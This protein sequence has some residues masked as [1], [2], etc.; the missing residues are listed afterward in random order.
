MKERRVF[1][2]LCCSVL[3]FLLSSLSGC[4]R[5]ASREAT[6]SRPLDQPRRPYLNEILDKRTVPD[7]VEQP[8]GMPAAGPSGSPGRRPAGGP[9]GAPRFQPFTGGAR[10]T[11][12]TLGQVQGFLNRFGYL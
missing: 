5:Q 3:A 2:A 1:Q 8:E 6:V 11:P 10:S 12:P 9:G 7:G 4:A